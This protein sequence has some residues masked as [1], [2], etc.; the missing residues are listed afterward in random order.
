M[1]KNK[2]D[3]KHLINAAISFVIAVGGFYVYKLLNSSTMDLF[4]PVI[5]FLVLIYLE[6]MDNK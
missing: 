6:L 5:F 4:V 3:K 1:E 2:F